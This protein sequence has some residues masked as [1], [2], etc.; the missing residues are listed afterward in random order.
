MIGSRVSRSLTEAALGCGY[1]STSACIAAF[2]RL[3][4]FTPGGLRL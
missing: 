3:F 4:G 1:D 2:K